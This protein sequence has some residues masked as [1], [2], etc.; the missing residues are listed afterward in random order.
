MTSICLY[1]TM[2][3]PFKQN[4]WDLDACGLHLIPFPP[5]LLN[6]MWT[7]L[8]LSYTNS[9]LM[10]GI[11]DLLVKSTSICP[12]IIFKTCL[13]F[14]LNHIYCCN[15]GQ[16]HLDNNRPESLQWSLNMPHSLILISVISTVCSTEVYLLK[17]K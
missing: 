13:F 3:Y 5:S 2:Y 10:K 14:F 9:P 4:F 17:S 16:C 8:F 12:S 6:S 15:F 11:N 7:L 1:P